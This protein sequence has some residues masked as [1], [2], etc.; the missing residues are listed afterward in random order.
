MKLKFH[1]FITTILVVLCTLNANGEISVTLTFSESDYQFQTN[2]AGNTYIFSNNP[3]DYYSNRFAPCL[4]LSTK[5]IALPYLSEI[6]YYDFEILDEKLI[7]ENI[8]LSA[9]VRPTTS[10][11][12]IDF[13][14]LDTPFFDFVSYPESAV[15]Y[16]YNYHWQCIPIACFE[17]TPFRYDVANRKLYFANK[18]KFTVHCKES[19]YVSKVTED[20]SE[21]KGMLKTWVVNTDDI[22]NIVSQIPV[23]STDYF[24][25]IDYILITTESQREEFQ[26]LVNWKR[27]RGI[28]AELVTV[29]QIK[30]WY[31]GTTIQEQI[32]HCIYD[33][34]YSY[35]CKFAVLGGDSIPTK[36]CYVSAFDSIT[37]KTYTYNDAPADKYYGCFNGNFGWNRNNNDLFGEIDDDVDFT[38]SVYVTRIPTRTKED[39]N[40]FIDKLIAFT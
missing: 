30:G 13:N 26:R 9:A 32:K 28:S 12:E 4:P 11:K 15:K 22:D 5:K 17:I 2:A 33:L 18:V 40:A 8:T 27:M 20:V 29:E 36:G 37:E 14:Q 35:G 31:P 1:K 24:P 25:E 19:N 6:D 3:Y 34:W 7:M 21:I 38:Q 39:T 23:V 10:M 16:T